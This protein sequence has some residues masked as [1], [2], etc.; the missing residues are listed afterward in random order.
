MG[1][2]RMGLDT[3]WKK[4]KK[5]QKKRNKKKQKSQIAVRPKN[6]QVQPAP[7]IALC[8]LFKLAWH[9]YITRFT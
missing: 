2:I 8:V 1:S 5:K 6:A 4:R 9:A 3:S 7:R